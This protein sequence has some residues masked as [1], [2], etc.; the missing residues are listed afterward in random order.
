MRKH[1]RTGSGAAGGSSRRGR[2]GIDLSSFV[3]AD[4]LEA[5]GREMDLLVT[6]GLWNQVLALR[7]CVR[8]RVPGHIRDIAS[9]V[10]M[11]NQA[12]IEGE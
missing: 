7:H 6:V 4:V 5:I 11:I 12:I 3:S 8:P 1:K 10:P 2:S 9:A